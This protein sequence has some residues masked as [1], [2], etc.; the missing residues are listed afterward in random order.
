[1]FQLLAT[2]TAIDVY[3]SLTARIGMKVLP[4]KATTYMPV[5][6]DALLVIVLTV[7]A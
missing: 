3:H 7:C 2:R 4:V 1:M 5:T 6:Q